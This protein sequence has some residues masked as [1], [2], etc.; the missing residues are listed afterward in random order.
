MEELVYVVKRDLLF[1]GSP[2]QGLS[3][4][5]GDFLHRCRNHGQFRPR[6]AVEDDPSFK[7]IIP[8]V[9]LFDAKHILCVRRLSAQSE[10]RLHGLLSLGIGG[11]MNPAPGEPGFT[12]LLAANARRELHEELFLDCEPDVT[13]V[14]FINDDGRPVGRVHAGLL[15]LAQV[16]PAR[17]RVR[18]TRQMRG[19]FAPYSQ[20]LALRPE[21]ESW[22]QLVL[23]H[24]PGLS[25][26]M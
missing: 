18:E 14:A 23:D 22:S 26:A 10:S 13:W 11:H 19:E 17:V 24:W 16:D 20:L 21:F 6:S 25:R 8:Y 7:Q 4:S 1:S 5:P 9:V 2:P 3:T 12:G 15:G